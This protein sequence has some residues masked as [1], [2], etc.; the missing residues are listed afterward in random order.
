VVRR[1]VVRRYPEKR[2]PEKRPHVGQALLRESAPRQV[3]K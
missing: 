3:R 1:M 2:Y